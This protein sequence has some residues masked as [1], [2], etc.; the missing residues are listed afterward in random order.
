MSPSEPDEA[1]VELYLGQMKAG[2]PVSAPVLVV[3]PDGRY[4]P[5][6]V[7][8]ASKIEAARRAGA[9]DIQGA[10]VVRAD[11]ETL[12]R[13]REDLGRGRREGN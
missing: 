11:P 1:L 9:R 8:C 6:T 3:Q 4:Y 12:A 13:L 7:E 10:V 5:L 2:K